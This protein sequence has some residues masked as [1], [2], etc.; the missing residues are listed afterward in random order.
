MADAY[1]A[2]RRLEHRVQFATGVQ[3]H[4]LPEPGDPLLER[5]ARSARSSVRS[6]SWSAISKRT[7]RRV[8]A[9][10]ASLSREGRARGARSGRAGAALLR[11]RC[12]GRE[13]DPGVAL[14]R[15]RRLR[16]PR[17]R[18][19]RPRPRP[20][21]RLSPRRCDARQISG[22]RARARRGA[23]RRGR[24][25][26]SG[27][28]DGDVLRPP[29]NAQRLR[30]RPRGGPASGAGARR[31]LRRER[32][33][34]RLDGRPPGARGPAPLRTR[35]AVSGEREARDRRG[36][37]VPRRGRDYRCRGLRRGAPPR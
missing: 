37:R 33:S 23:L 2:L 32:I 6:G 36:A 10:F 13:R 24:S 5:I 25:R 26:A 3:T 7:R 20:P 12:G 28:L 21:P 30:A 4:T 27:A 34:R 18:A 8:A 11:D 22:A 16:F 14:E 1:L 35:R 29:G 9:R 31:A 19:P 17:S 15:I